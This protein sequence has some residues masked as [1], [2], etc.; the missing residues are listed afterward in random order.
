MRLTLDALA[1]LPQVRRLVAAQEDIVSEAR[2]LHHPAGTIIRVSLSTGSFN[3]KKVE[4]FGEYKA[5]HF[6]NG[7]KL[8]I[9]TVIDQGHE[10]VLCGEVD[11]VSVPYPVQHEALSI[12]FARGLRQSAACH[13]GLPPALRNAARAG[14]AG[15]THAACGQAPALRLVRDALPRGR[16]VFLDRD[17]KGQLGR[18]SCRAA[19]SSRCSTDG[20]ESLGRNLLWC[21][22]RIWKSPGSRSSSTGTG[23][24]IPFARGS[25]GLSGTAISA[26]IRSARDFRTRSRRQVGGRECFRPRQVQNP[27]GPF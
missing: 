4:A 17:A 22:Q 10:A 25:S 8:H 1:L 16:G 7:G 19:S 9:E 3:A 11:V 5:A 18:A 13:A 20:I 2:R 21:G 6:P 26:L 12:F 24:L 15:R 27:P 23:A 14:G